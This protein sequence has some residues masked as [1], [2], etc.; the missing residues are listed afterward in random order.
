MGCVALSFHKHPCPHK[1][2]LTSSEDVQSLFNAALEGIVEASKGAFEKLLCNVPRGEHDRT[3]EAEQ[4][5]SIT[6][7][8]LKSSSAGKLATI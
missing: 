7:S 4:S 8:E 6:K 1:G 2:V 5:S 3:S